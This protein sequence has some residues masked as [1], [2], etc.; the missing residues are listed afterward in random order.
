TLLHTH[1]STLLH[2]HAH[3]Y[4]H[5]YTHICT[6]LPTHTH[7][8]IH[9]YPL[10]QGNQGMRDSHIPYYLFPIT[11]SLIPYLSTL[12]LL[13]THTH[14]YKCTVTCI[15]LTYSVTPSYTIRPYCTH[16]HTHIH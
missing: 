14:T 10:Q 4:I 2:T 6:H 16:I 1:P 15:M 5:S 9:T 11:Y 13:H 7:S 12:I 8:H 3:T